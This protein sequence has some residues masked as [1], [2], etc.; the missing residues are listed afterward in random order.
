MASGPNMAQLLHFEL[1]KNFSQ[2]SN[3]QFYLSLS[4]NQVQL[5]KNPMKRSREKFRSNTLERNFF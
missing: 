3:G 5:H 2:K 4:D 1:N